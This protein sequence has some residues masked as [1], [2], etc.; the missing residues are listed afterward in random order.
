M[1]H[2]TASYVG[3]L[4]TDSLVNSV[5]AEARH[6]FLHDIERLIVCDYQG[7]VERHFVYD[8]IVA[9]TAPDC[10][11]GSG[12]LPYRRLHDSVVIHHVRRAGSD[13]RRPVPRWAVRLRR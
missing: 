3:W 2:S 4:R 8:L 11:T 1:R 5:G 10:K 12:R 7:T 6:G 13:L 9:N